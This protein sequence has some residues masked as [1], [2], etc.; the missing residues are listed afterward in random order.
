MI[1]LVR[2][3]ETE[4]SRSRRHTGRTDIPLTEAGRR[5]AAELRPVLDR[6]AP[7]TVLSSPLRRARETATLTGHGSAAVIDDRL[8]EWDYGSAEGRT[9]AELRQT[10]PGWSVWTHPIDG[11]EQL[12]DVSKRVDD[13]VEDLAALP[14]VIVVFG[15]AHLFRILAARWCGLPPE[16]GARFVLDPASL[17]TLGYE[18]TTRCV[19][20]WNAGVDRHSFG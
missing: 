18:R 12:A 3:G 5:Q 20:R 7:D 11:G 9:T 13:L 6:L 4:W 17:S 14:G 15:H 2:H 8:R 16:A 1:H 10:E 19:I